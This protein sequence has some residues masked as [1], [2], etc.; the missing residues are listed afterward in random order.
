[1]ANFIEKERIYCRYITTT[2]N[3]YLALLL[4]TYFKLLRKIS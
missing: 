2:T 4:E 3:F 1:M